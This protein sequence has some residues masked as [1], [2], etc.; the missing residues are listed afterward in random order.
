MPTHEAAV[1]T[2]AHKTKANI[3]THG[4]N[5]TLP[6]TI[7]NLKGPSYVARD[8]AGGRNAGLQCGSFA[9]AAHVAGPASCAPSWQ[10][11][12]CMRLIDEKT[13]M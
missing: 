2:A 6:G 13:N 4:A 5:R 3:A 1:N 10:M 7:P 11:T 8:G 12:G 9:D